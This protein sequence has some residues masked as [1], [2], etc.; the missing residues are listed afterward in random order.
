MNTAE[1]PQVASSRAIVKCCLVLAIPSAGLSPDMR[2]G[3]VLGLSSVLIFILLSH[4]RTDRSTILYWRCM[5]TATAA[6]ALGIFLGAVW[7]G[8]QLDAGT[9][10]ALVVFNVVL[11]GRSPDRHASARTTRMVRGALR[12]GSL[13]LAV[14]TSLLFLKA[15]FGDA[16]REFSG[17]LPKPLHMPWL[18]YPGGLFLVTGLLYAALDRSEVEP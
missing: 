16:L 11:L 7:P 2:A 15:L 14:L 8:R 4:L 3:L 17:S 9:F 18:L 5:L 12:T 6:T 13:F 10:T 1:N